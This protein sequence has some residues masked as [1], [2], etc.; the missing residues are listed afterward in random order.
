MGMKSPAT[1]YYSRKLKVTSRSKLSQEI[2]DAPLNRRE[3]EFICDV[4]EGLTL[5]E[6]ADKY[7]L[8][9]SRISKW[10]REI[11]E[12]MLAYDMSCARR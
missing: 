10:K 9:T 2:D 12:R 6:L 5:Q 1:T 4:A 7:N 11:F 3:R 8:S